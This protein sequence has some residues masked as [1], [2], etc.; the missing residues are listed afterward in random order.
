MLPVWRRHSWA[1]QQ[2]DHAPEPDSLPWTLDGLADIA[3]ANFPYQEVTLTSDAD[4]RSDGGVAAYRTQMEGLKTFNGIVFCTQAMLCYD[5]L[6]RRRSTREFSLSEAQY[7]ERRADAASRHVPL[8]PRWMYD[9]EY[10]VKTET[11]G[12]GLL[13]DYKELIVDEAHLLPAAI[14][15][16]C[17]A[18]VSLFKLKSALVHANAKKSMSTVE[19]CYRALVA[20]SESSGKSTIF[21][22]GDS[23]RGY[24]DQCAIQFRELLTAVK[25]ARASIPA[26]QRSADAKLATRVADEAIAALEKAVQQISHRDGGTQLYVDFSPVRR[27]PRLVA[28]RK[29][30]DSY[31]DYLWRRTRQAAVVSATLYTPT[32]RGY[33]NPAYM[34]R[35]LSIP[36]DSLRTCPAR[37]PSWLTNGVELWT[38][39]PGNTNDAGWLEPPR[40]S[41]LRD[42]NDQQSSKLASK[43]YEEIAG[44]I[45]EIANS[46][47]GG[48]LVLCTS[49]SDL[50]GILKHLRGSPIEDRLIPATHELNTIGLIRFNVLK[51]RFMHR[52]RNRERPIW[53]T[54]GQ[55][56]T[57]L[58]LSLSDLPPSDDYLLT[59]LV[60]TKVPFSRPAITS[61]GQDHLR[62]VNQ[63]VMTLRQG[64]GRLI[65]REGLKHRRI[66]VLDG[67]VSKR[68]AGLQQIE[69]LFGFYK[70]R[71]FWEVPKNAQ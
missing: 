19:Q 5:L 63:A 37:V 67:G 61:N 52:G 31:L 18:E 41:K 21:V 25:R 43:W 57:G 62:A 66:H 68:K 33:E 10:R 38:P 27:Y 42:L 7:R 9:N 22:G 6:A 59:D 13:P 1:K 40:I 45:L 65:R 28:E 14:K 2:Q 3:P 69:Y 17:S 55:A 20:I 70:K 4:D 34:A 32:V 54:T 53:V 64:M 58:D 12:C 60:I 11:P 26:R 47:K 16:A 44:I 56:W 46:A 39:K 30:I 23:S 36:T 49:Y 51:A 8:Q 48:M 50:E 15:N 29:Q 35:Q 24:G 71:R